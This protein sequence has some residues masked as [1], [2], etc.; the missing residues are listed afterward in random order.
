MSSHKDKAIETLIRT[1]AD[2]ERRLSD[3]SI[4]D[5]PQKLQKYSKEKSKLQPVITLIESRKSVVAQLDDVLGQIQKEKDREFVAILKEEKENLSQQLEDLDSQIEY[6]L[7]PKDPDQ[8][9]NMFVEIR[10]GTGGDEAALFVRD[11]FR[12][13]TRYLESISIKYEIISMVETGLNGFKEI[14][15]LIKDEKAYDMFHLEAG[16]HRVQRIPETESQGRIHTSACTVAVIPEVEESEIKI[17][18]EDLRIDV[19]RSSGAGGQHVNTTDSAVRITHIPTGLVVTCQDEKSQ[20]KNKAKALKVLSAR[21]IQRE[22]DVAHEKNAADKKSQV[23]SGDRSEKIRTYNFPQNRLTDH[24]IN[25]TSH[26]LEKMLDG[27]M[28]DLIEALMMYERKMQLES[29]GLG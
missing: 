24:R 3:P 8:G 11:L 21:L 2:L 22:K 12:M 14:I 16:T 10:A 6:A 5:D 19:Y 29:A 20:H 28:G 17:N 15:F 25:F 9:K 26:N 13:Y 27:E 7:L 18:N 23:G 4:G 1:Y